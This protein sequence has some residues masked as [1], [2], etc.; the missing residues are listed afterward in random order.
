MIKIPSKV[1]VGAI[2]YSVDE[3]Y[4]ED[5]SSVN[6]GKVLSTTR[7]LVNIGN[8][9]FATCRI[10]IANELKHDIKLHSLL[11]EICHAHQRSF[12]LDEELDE[13]QCNLFAT[14]ILQFINDNIEEIKWKEGNRE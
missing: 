11:H 6:I 2:T 5:V 10:K 1:K 7:D 13:N 3:V 9:D 14:I 12:G 8:I 4:F